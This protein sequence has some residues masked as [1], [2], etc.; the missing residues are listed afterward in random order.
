MFGWKTK[1]NQSEIE[2]TI[3]TPVINKEILD[4]QQNVQ[5]LNAENEKR[6]A[7]NEK[8]NQILN[9]HHT[10]IAAFQ[11]S[12]NKILNDINNLTASYNSL[13]AETDLN[14][15]NINQQL[16]D[17]QQSVER[18]ELNQNVSE[19]EEI[20]TG[21]EKR[22]K[23][24]IQGGDYYVDAIREVYHTSPEFNYILGQWKKIL[25]ANENLTKIH[26]ERYEW[27]ARNGILFVIL[28]SRNAGNLSVIGIPSMLMRENKISI[29]A[30]MYDDFVNTKII[31][32]SYCKDPFSRNGDALRHLK[33]EEFRVKLIEENN[34][35]SGKRNVK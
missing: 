9:S 20:L 24:R 18:L 28:H 13:K 21:K 7:A 22:E 10:S 17:I 27:S 35:L 15:Q 26:H 12:L 14:I 30:N 6:K 11:Q 23:R 33:D 31:P 34:Q 29:S 4:M 25:N 8:L 2:S 16:L 32:E 1:E 3:F 5:N 19:I